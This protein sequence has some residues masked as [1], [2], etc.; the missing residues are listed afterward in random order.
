MAEVYPSDNTLLNIES[1][2]E[3]GVE[4]IATGQSP[5]YLQFRAH[6]QC[7]AFGYHGQPGNQTGTTPKNGDEKN[8]PNAKTNGDVT[9]WSIHFSDLCGKIEESQR[10][11]HRERYKRT[12]D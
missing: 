11:K 8:Y 10:T 3:T 7:L 9:F 1:E 2:S 4:Y 12:K 5:Y 6:S